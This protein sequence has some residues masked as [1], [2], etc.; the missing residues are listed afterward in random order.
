MSGAIERFED[1]LAQAEELARIIG[2]LR[3]SVEKK[4]AEQKGGSV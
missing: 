1:L 2:G 3:L 4:R